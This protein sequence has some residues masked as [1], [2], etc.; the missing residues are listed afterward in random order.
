MYLDESWS[1]KNVAFKK[2]WQH[3]EVLRVTT[4]VNSSNRFITL[5]LESYTSF[6]E[7]YSGRESQTA[8]V[9]GDIMNPKIRILPIISVNDLLGGQ[10]SR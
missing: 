3:K 2:C 4:N 8:K 7:G 10:Y 1:D 5:V 6:V 9:E